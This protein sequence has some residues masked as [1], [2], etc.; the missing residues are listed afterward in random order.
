M[1][2]TWGVSGCTCPRCTVRCPRSLVLNTQRAHFTLHR[3]HTPQTRWT[4]PETVRLAQPRPPCAVTCRDLRATVFCS[5]R[6]IIVWGMH[7]FVH[8]HVCLCTVDTGGCVCTYVC[9]L[10]WVASLITFHLIFWV[11][12]SHRM[13]KLLIPLDWPA[14][15]PRCLSY[16]SF[17]Y[18]ETRW[19]GQLTE[20]SLFE[21]HSSRGIGVHDDRV[22]VASHRQLSTTSRKRGELPQNNTSPSEPQSPSPETHFLQWG[23]TS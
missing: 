7:M 21:A 22:K 15:E 16:A 10:R 11:N 20:E 13:L 14:R 6:N 17:C 18:K 19:P 4:Q 23:L 3:P 9:G 2:Q 12:V 8:V 1:P 5:Y